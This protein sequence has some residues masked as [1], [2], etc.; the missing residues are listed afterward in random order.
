M[1]SFST[2]LVSNLVIPNQREEPLFSSLPSP[3]PSFRTERADFF[4]LRS[5]E[6][7][8]RVE[9]NLSSLCRSLFAL[10]LSRTVIP[11]GAGR[12]PSHRSFLRTVGLRK[13]ESLLPL[14]HR[15]EFGRDESVFSSPPP[16]DRHSEWSRPIF[17]TPFA[18]ANGRPAQ[19]GISLRFASSLRLL[20]SPLRPALTPSF[21][22]P[23]A[24]AVCAKRALR[25]VEKS[26]AP[27]AK[28][29]V[30]TTRPCRDKHYKIRSPRE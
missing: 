30:W 15:G 28:P 26:N 22:K 12:F 24:P 5:R 13:E 17:S 14:R 19:R 11:S 23:T 1:E 25:I 21:R 16:L 3:R 4:P 18:P 7:S 9:R 27:H 6:G 2:Q 8:A 29:G 20:S 10:P